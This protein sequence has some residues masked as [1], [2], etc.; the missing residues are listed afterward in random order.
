MDSSRGSALSRGLAA[1]IIAA[2]LAGGVAVVAAPIN[3]FSTTQP[4]FSKP[5]WTLALLVIAMVAAPIVAATIAVERVIGRAFGDR[6]DNR[7]RGL[8]P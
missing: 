3:Y 2:I 8:D 4:P 6:Q 1:P 5:Q 7:D